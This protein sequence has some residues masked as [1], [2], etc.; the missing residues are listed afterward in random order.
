M[1]IQKL[2]VTCGGSS[3]QRDMHKC[4]NVISAMSKKTGKSK[5]VHMPYIDILHLSNK[6][7]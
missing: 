6:W 4:M 2:N 7:R 1:V 5:N 3:I